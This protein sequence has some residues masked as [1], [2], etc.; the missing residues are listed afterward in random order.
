MSE[1]SFRSER[2]KGIKKDKESK[3]GSVKEWEEHEYDDDA[4][5]AGAIES[6]TDKKCH[7]CKWC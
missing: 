4:T 1:R 5:V 7:W 3:S 6:C 2:S